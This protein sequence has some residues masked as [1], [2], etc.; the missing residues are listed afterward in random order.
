MAKARPRH[1]RA[2]E[3]QTIG[4]LQNHGA[5]TVDSVRI[6]TDGIWLIENRASIVSK[7]YRTPT[8]AE[9]AAKKRVSQLKRKGYSEEHPAL[10]TILPQV[11]RFPWLDEL[12]DVCLSF[13]VKDVSEDELQSL[14][15]MSRWGPDVRSQMEQSAFGHYLEKVDAIAPDPSWFPVIKKATD[16]WKHCSI[17]AVRPYGTNIIVVDAT[18]DWEEDGLEWCIRDDTL[19][20]LG[21]SVFWPASDSNTGYFSKACRRSTKALI[22]GIAG[23]KKLTRGWK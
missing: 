20:S 1:S 3:R 6:E 18:C 10:G 4:F 15:M 16:I 12:V 22:D 8:A 5:D 11:V 14:A 7:R 21:N 17:G 2:L 23:R 9:K 19:I 13:H